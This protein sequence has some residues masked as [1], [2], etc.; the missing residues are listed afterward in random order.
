MALIISNNLVVNQQQ[1]TGKAGLIGYQNLL[2]VNNVTASSE[3]PTN[4]ITNVANPATAYTWESAIADYAGA[5]SY[6]GTNQM[7]SPFDPE[8][9]YGATSDPDGTITNVTM[10]NPSGQAF[11]GL[12]EQTGT[13]SF[14]LLNSGSN[15]IA[16][17]NIAE[18]LYS[19][20][21][22]KIG[23][24][25]STL[26]YYLGADQ[27]STRENTT[28][29][30]LNKTAILGGNF[31]DYTFTD[32]VDGFCLLKV[33]YSTDIDLTNV[34]QVFVMREGENLVPSI[35]SQLY[36]QAAY[37]GKTPLEYP[38]A[39]YNE[40]DDSAET[41]DWNPV[42]CAIDASGGLLSIID[43]R[44]DMYIETVGL[45]AFDGGKYT[46][47]VTRWRRNVGSVSNTLFWGN[48]SNPSFNSTNS[49][50]FDELE[51]DSRVKITGPDSDGFYTSI[52]DLSTTSSWNGADGVITGLR[53]DY[54]QNLP[55][56][57][58]IDYI[59]TYS[60]S[61]LQAYEE[62]SPAII[63]PAGIKIDIS[64]AGQSIDYLG[65]ARHNL[66]Q[67]GLSVSLKFDGITVLQNQTVSDIQAVMLL[68]NEASPDNV[69][70][71]INGATNAPQIGVIYIG[72][73]LQ[74]ERNIYV[75]H[76]PVT[77]G[78]NRKTVNGV[79]E[80][81]QY[82]GEIVVRQNNS[83]SVNLQ[84]LTP[85][86][87]R[88]F[89]DPFFKLTPRVPCFWA[90]RPQDYLAEVGYCWVEGEPSMSN[91]RSNGMVECSWNFKGIA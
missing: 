12:A 25:N 58:D 69:Q 44:T 46:H 27:S 84:N 74:L 88:S 77:Y 30:L 87:Y 63:D 6:D 31:I 28:F 55:S 86:W 83:T 33:K 24:Y 73:A 76:T 32:L 64:T 26:Q 89:L 23:N 80:N 1:E 62:W 42:R 54:G 53:F 38:Y 34:S 10:P 29:D 43:A 20:I 59:K 67:A 17:V 39:Q 22:Y 7:A 37:F 47:V 68:V 4:P 35:G 71:I 57:F 16:N 15:K 70:L 85:D 61:L 66:N 45:T 5:I 13:G 50:G 65:I 40:F 79:S 3:L 2:N 72:K 8:G 21:I 41:S 91:Q 18:P 49:I 19:S 60:P 75:G 48:T 9:W 14:I 90:W 36:V 52:I 51:T 81:G 78:R 11:V 56:D 82:L